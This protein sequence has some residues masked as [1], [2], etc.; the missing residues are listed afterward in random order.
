MKRGGRERGERG[1]GEGRTVVALFDARPPEAQCLAVGGWWLVRGVVI[2]V[3]GVRCGVVRWWGE[4]R[5]GIVVLVCA[6]GW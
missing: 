3:Y 2:G 1:E 4:V 6:C 5:C